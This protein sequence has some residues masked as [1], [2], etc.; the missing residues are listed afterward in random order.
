MLELSILTLLSF[1][2]NLNKL[3]V[4]YIVLNEFERVRQ[5]EEVNIIETALRLKEGHSNLTPSFVCLYYTQAI[6]IIFRLTVI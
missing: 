5:T 2:S 6:L 3:G 1:R 4:F